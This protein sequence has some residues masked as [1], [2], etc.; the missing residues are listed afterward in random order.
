MSMICGRS[1]TTTLTLDNACEKIGRSR[2]KICA[3]LF[4]ATTI[5]YVDRQV[6][7]LLKPLLQDQVSGIGLTEVNY[8]YI[9]TAFSLAYALG[10]LLV[11]SF[12]DRVGTRLGYAVAVGVW[13]LGAASHSLVS[14]PQVTAA[15]SGVVH[16]LGTVLGWKDLV[17]VSGAVAGFAIARFV[18]G[19]G[20]SG[21]F[22]AGIKTVAE[23]FPQ[24]ERALATGIFNSGANV[25]AL[26]A[27]LA[28]PWIAIHWGWRWGFLFTAL[29]S[30]SW[31]VFW[32]RIYRHPQEHP[33]VS[34]AELAYIDSA[35]RESVARIPWSRLLS[36]RQ[37][38]AIFL[39][40]VLTDPVWW[41][42]LYWVPGFLSRRY[43]LTI[44]RIGLPLVVIY[45]M[46]AVGSIGGGWLPC[47]FLSLGW[48]ANRARKTAMLLYAIAALPVVLVGRMQGVW[49]VV[50]LLSLATAAHQAWS[51]NMFTLASD[52]FPGRAVASVVGIGTFGAALVMAFISTLVGYVL[53]WTNGNYAPLFVACGSGY[54]LALLILQV[55]APKLRM[56][57]LD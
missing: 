57:E 47:K 25:G 40:K 21:N 5:N 46:S 22:P 1:V 20:E 26:I 7:A 2:W 43:G 8:G 18:L 16:W 50:A 49:S 37:A 32:W 34:P 29:F 28:V 11:G 51:A 9:V 56:A 4:V 17:S 3:L 31:I 45:N 53:K 42:Y 15:L 54:L 39:G 44:G 48:S 38:W 41:F 55:L 24:K 12:I 19:L 6:L 52:M 33:E 10:L 13:G 35:P 14:F 23:W 36:Q 27:P 30:A